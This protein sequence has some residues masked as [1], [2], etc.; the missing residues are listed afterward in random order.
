MSTVFDAADHCTAQRTNLGN[1]DPVASVSDLHVTYERNG[2]PV[3]AV[4]GVDLDIRRGEVLAVVGESGSGKT[5]LSKALL[6]LL[7][8]HDGPLITGSVIVDGVDLR[9]ANP[10]AVRKLRRVA[11]G[12]VFQDSSSSLNPTLRIGRQLDEATKS[13][14]RSVALLERVG[15]PEPAKRMASYPHE[16]SGGLR[17]R[18]II[19][20]AVAGDPKLVVC[21]EPTTALDVTVQAQILALLRRMRDE[22]GSSMFFITHDLGVAAEVADRIAVMYQGQ[23]VEIGDTAEILER[24][25]NDYTRRLLEARIGLDTP[26]RAVARNTALLPADPPSVGGLSLEGVTKTYSLRTSRWRHA[27]LHALADV[28]LDI[29]PGE[30]VALVG[31]S[32]SGKSTLLR[33]LAGLEDPTSGAIR[34]TTA[35][36]PQMVFQDAGESLTPWLTVREILSDPLRGVSREESEDRVAS[37]IRAVGLAEEIADARPSELSGGQKQRVVIARAVVV[38]PTTLLCDEPTS[39]LDSPV[40][41]SVLWLLGQLRADLDMTMVFVTHD[42]AV[43]RL[44]AD[45]IA[46]MYLGRIVEVLPADAV[47]SAAHPYTQALL[48]SVPG[49]GRSPRALRGEPASPIHAPSGCSFHPRCHAAVPLCSSRPVEL[50]PRSDRHDVACPEAVQ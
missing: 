37:I 8:V 43:A 49:Q 27:E 13:T 36:R 33:I 2:S 19:A 18:V 23:I 6:G 38:P 25:T 24:P 11:L 34:R 48:D 12:A 7:P 41:R 17:Q 16:L 39:A 42:L 5:V 31:E 22:L 50:T 35:T 46:V 40:A 4:R 14:D 26:R 21:D 3:N 20:L 9:A 28:S 32:G 45:R 10:K 15:I 1:A 30:S 29:A 47:R 44:V